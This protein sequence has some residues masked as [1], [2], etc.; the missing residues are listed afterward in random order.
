GELRKER[1]FPRPIVTIS[2][3]VQS[4]AVTPFIGL[5]VRYSWSTSCLLRSRWPQLFLTDQQDINW[6]SSSSAARSS[7]RLSGGSPRRSDGLSRLRNRRH[8]PAG[9]RRGNRP[10]DYATILY[11]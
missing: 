5:S 8:I 4:M 2:I 11:S 9:Q 1:R 6:H 10:S 3:S 7:G